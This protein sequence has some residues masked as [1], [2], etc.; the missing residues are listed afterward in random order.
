M[1]DIKKKIQDIKIA[2]MGP[3]YRFVNNIFYDLEPMQIKL[4][5]ERIFF[6]KSGIPV[7]EFIPDG[8]YLWVHNEIIW[9]PLEHIFGYNEYYENIILIRKILSLFIKNYFNLS[10]VTVS[11]ASSKVSDNWETFE[12]KPKNIL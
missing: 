4:K 3:E 7:M 11:I 5:P 2:R 10:D 9:R 8:R 6:V 1:T 12:F